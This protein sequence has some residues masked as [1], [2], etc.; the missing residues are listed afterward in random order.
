MFFL[1]PFKYSSIFELFQTHTHE[2]PVRIV[3]Q[4][5]TTK[6]YLDSIYARLKKDAPDCVRNSSPLLS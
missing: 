6:L 5:H 4:V 1:I 2:Y 3:Y